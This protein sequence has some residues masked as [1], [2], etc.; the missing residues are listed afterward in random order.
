[1]KRGKAIWAAY[2]DTGALE[3]ACPNC[4]ADQGHWCTKPDGRVSRV[5]CVSRAAAASLTVAHT[6]KYRDF[7]EPRHPPTGH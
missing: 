1:M 4:S 6:D 5:P 7:S 2:G 3:V